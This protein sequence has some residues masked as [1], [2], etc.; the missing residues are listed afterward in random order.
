[1]S[2]E[3]NDQKKEPTKVTVGLVLGWGLGVLAAISG[4]TLLF[5]EPLT[6]ILM[7]LLAAVLLPPANKFVA[8][9]FN[10]SISGGMK[11]IVVIGLL[12]VIGISAPA[13]S[14][15]GDIVTTDNDTSQN[16]E[17]ETNTEEQNVPAANNDSDSTTPTQNQPTQA[18]IEPEPEP[19]TPSETVSQKNALRKAKSYLNYTAFSRDGLVE[20]LKFDQFSHADAVYGADNSGADWY[21]QTAKKAQSYM[22]YSAF[23]RGSLIEQ[24]KF[25]G[26]TQSQAEHGADAV[27]L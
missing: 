26:F 4:V 21:E 11:V 6:G 17:N 10:F 27:G 12:I 13:D 7:L 16:Q 9:K 24:L 18:Q 22:E 23:S 1:M 19:V 2:E 3:Q 8:D 25:D 14:Q 15:T 20:Q 5:S